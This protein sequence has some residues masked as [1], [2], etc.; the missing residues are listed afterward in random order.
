[1]DMPEVQPRVHI[2]LIAILKQTEIMLLE[3]ISVDRITLLSQKIAKREYK[4]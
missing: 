1:M 3:T 2:G 4:F